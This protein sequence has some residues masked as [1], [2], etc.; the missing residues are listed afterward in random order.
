MSAALFV[1]VG[2]AFRHLQSDRQAV[3]I[4]EGMNP[5]LS[6]GHAVAIPL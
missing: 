1:V 5:R 4:E 2:L 6:R 3:G